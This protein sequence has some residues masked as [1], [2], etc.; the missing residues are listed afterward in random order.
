MGRIWPVGC[1][2]QTPFLDPECWARPLDFVLRAVG[3]Y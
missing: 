3:S 1:S 2:L